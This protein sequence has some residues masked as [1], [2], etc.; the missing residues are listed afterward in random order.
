MKELKKEL[1]L[2]FENKDKFSKFYDIRTLKTKECELSFE[3]YSVY[4]NIIRFLKPFSLS[5]NFDKKGINLIEP[6][7]QTDHLIIYVNGICSTVEMSQYQKEWLEKIFDNPVTLAYNYTD[8][9]ILDVYECMQDRT[10]KDNGDT[11]ASKKLYEYIEE[12]FEKYKKVTVVGFSQGCLITGRALERLSN[13]VDSK[14]LVNIDYITFANPIN[15]LDLPKEIS[16]EHFIN[17]ED[18]VANIGIIEHNAEIKGKKYYQNK[19]GHLFVADYLIPLVLGRFKKSSFEKKYLNE[20]LKNDIKKGL[21]K[22]YFK[23]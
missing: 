1:K 14:K 7:K 3:H 2:F 13:N 11:L 10:Y 15:S 6:P 23:L 4:E 19:G 9:F 18:P 22:I 20:K 17:K 5:G 12:N 8:G 16:I 21:S